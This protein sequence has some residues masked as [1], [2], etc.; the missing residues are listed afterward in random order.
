MFSMVLCRA[1][2]PPLPPPPSPSP[3]FA[4]DVPRRPRPC[5]TRRL[6]AEVLF[7][8]SFRAHST[9]PQKRSRPVTG[10]AEPSTST[11]PQKRSRPVTGQA[12]PST[13]GWVHGSTCRDTCLMIGE[14]DRPPT[15]ADEG[16]R[17]HYV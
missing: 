2:Q 17:R 12:E 1:S 11:A 10:Q 3:M 4:G 8:Y 13:C 16:T 5:A 6:V 9:A 14:L 7:V 15:L